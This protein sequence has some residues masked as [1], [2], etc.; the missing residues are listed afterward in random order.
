MGMGSVP[1][2]GVAELSQIY[3]MFPVY[4]TGP[5][6]QTHLICPICPICKISASIEKLPRQYLGCHR[7]TRSQQSRKLPGDFPPRSLPWRRPSRTVVHHGGF[8]K[9]KCFQIHKGDAGLC[10]RH[11]FAPLYCAIWYS[12]RLKVTSA[13]AV[14]GLNPTSCVTRLH[15]TRL[16]RSTNPKQ[17]PKQRRKDGAT[18][19]DGRK[20]ERLRLIALPAAFEK[21]ADL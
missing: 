9:E 20:P 17:T 12:W 1:P 3:Q 2:P 16:R 10:L 19:I 14:L 15:K 21:A 4:Q 6:C 11:S 7:R 8:E 5:I 18:E 13:I